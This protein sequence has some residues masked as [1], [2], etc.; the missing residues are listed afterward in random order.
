MKLDGRVSGP[1]TDEEFNLAEQPRLTRQLE[2]FMQLP[3]RPWQHTMENL[4]TQVDDRKI[5]LIHD[6]VGNV[7][8]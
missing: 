5:I 8:K 6:Q 3:L 7:G 4:I 1:W 2:A